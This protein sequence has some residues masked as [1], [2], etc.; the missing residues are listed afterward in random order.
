M[1]SH[2]HKPVAANYVSR[3]LILVASMFS[4]MPAA[5]A[6]VDDD[7]KF[8]FSVG[9]FLT[10]RNSETSVDGSLGMSGTTVDLERGLGLNSS[11]S[12]FRIDGYYRFNQKHRL[13]FSAF[14]LSRSA[15]MA[16][17][18]D[19]DW[20]GTVFPV[21]TVVDSGFDLEIYKLAYTWSFIQREKGY[22][23]MTAGLYVADIGLSLV[24][25]AIGERESRG[26]TAP[27]PVIGLRGQYDFNEKLSFR[28]SGEVFAL[29]Y[30]DFDG[31]LYDFYAGLDY[32]FFKH[33][34]I[35]IGVNSVSFDI[36][37]TRENFI[38]NL[39]WQ[40]DGGLVFF[41]FDF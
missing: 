9:V 23:G 36:G 38:G 15:S 19:I 35:G 34:A 41:K 11:D 40:Y 21:G 20:N 2:S 32:Q 10:D 7:T 30:G 18:S 24:G 25:E 16:I 5:M 26:I 27:L 14:D 8:S 28:A 13:D 37:I 6:Q 29:E 4:E 39:D 1:H 22:L 33:M 17:Q 3:M 12:V 31:S